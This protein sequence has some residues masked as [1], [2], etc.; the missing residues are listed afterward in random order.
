MS[1]KRLGTNVG[2]R[3]SEAF[4]REVV[5]DLE[6]NDLPFMAAQRKYGVLGC[7]TVQKWVRKYGNG[8]RGKVVRV[9]KPEE[10]NELGRLRKRV[11]L[12]EGALA[13]SNLDLALERAYVRLACARAGMTM[14]RGSK[15]KPMARRAPS[16]REGWKVAGRQR[17][18]AVPEGGDEPAELLRAAQAKAEAP[19]GRGAGGPA[20]APGTAGPA[21]PG[22]AQTAACAARP[23]G[24]SRGGFGAGPL[25]W[26]VAGGGFAGRTV[27]AG[28]GAHDVFAA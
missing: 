27:A 6:A 4:K 26:S 9:E 13:D 1:E 21:A 8:T 28:L 20:G 7:D 18:G 12:L 17:P 23:F 22:G 16:H 19:G 10:I 3:Y 5:R 15:K 25:L 2:I 11:R 14:W 24:P